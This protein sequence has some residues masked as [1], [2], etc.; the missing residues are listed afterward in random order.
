MSDKF[1]IMLN[2]EDQ[3]KVKSCL[4]SGQFSSAGDLIRNGIELNHQ[5]L[6]A[7]REINQQLR[8]G[9]TSLHERLER[10]L[11]TNH[12]NNNDL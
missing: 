7:N 8:A 11:V 12:Q 6:E 2:E 4:A 10:Y 9:L 3:E 1:Y 5:K